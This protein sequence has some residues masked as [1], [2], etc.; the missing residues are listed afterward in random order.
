MCDILCKIKKNVNINMKKNVTFID[1]LVDMDSLT[2]GSDYIT[3]GNMER[4]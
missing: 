1:D 2:R 3:K 4:D